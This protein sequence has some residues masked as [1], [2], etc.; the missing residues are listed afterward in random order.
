MEVSARRRFVVLKNFLGSVIKSPLRFEEQ[1][2][3]KSLLLG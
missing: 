1:L 2:A 3:K